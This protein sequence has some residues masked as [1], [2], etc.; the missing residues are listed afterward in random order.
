MADAE[1]PGRKEPPFLRLDA[2]ED[3]GARAV[4]QRAE[5][6]FARSLVLGGAI[7]WSALRSGGPAVH[8]AFLT[9]MSRHAAEKASSE[10]PTNE[11]VRDDNAAGA[12][13]AK[14][15]VSAKPPRSR[16]RK[17][18][19]PRVRLNWRDRRTPSLDFRWQ[20]FRAGALVT[21]AIGLAAFAV[22]FWHNL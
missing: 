6:L 1:E 7:D 8:Q 19:R 13:E 20:A 17:K 21:T 11:S 2:I 3:E 15:D 12:A 5:E 4:R 9:L 16:V 18:P 14:A 22:I 10:T